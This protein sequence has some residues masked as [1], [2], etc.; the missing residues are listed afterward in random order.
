MKLGGFMLGFKRLQEG[1]PQITLYTVD[2][3]VFEV[4]NISN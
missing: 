2:L 4:I 1:W 3:K